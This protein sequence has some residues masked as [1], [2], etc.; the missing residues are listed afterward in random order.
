MS[1]TLRIEG[2]DDAALTRIA[3]AAGISKNEA[4][5]RA[6]RESAERVSRE[7]LFEAALADTLSRYSNTL[8][9]LGE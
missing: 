9:R 1:M 6:I 5:L 2:E 4:A 3:K 8:K 7:T